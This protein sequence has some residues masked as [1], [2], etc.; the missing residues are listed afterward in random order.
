VKL[1]STKLLVVLKALM[2]DLSYFAFLIFS[3]SL[4]F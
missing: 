1:Q 3:P 4:S 2:I